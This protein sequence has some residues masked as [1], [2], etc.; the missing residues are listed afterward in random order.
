M[1]KVL[2]LFALSALFFSTSRAADEEAPALAR[3]PIPADFKL[4]IQLYGAGQSPL[5]G[6]ELVIRK[7]VAYEFVNDEPE[8]ITIIE[9]DRARLFLLD[10]KRKIQTELSARELD[11]A[12]ARIHQ[13]ITAS[14]EAQEK[15]GGKAN[16]IAASMNRNLC[17]PRLSITRDPAAHRLRLTN[18]SIEIDALGVPE[19]DQARVMSIVNSLAAFAKLA[20]LREPEN[21]SPFAYL[22]TLAALGPGE[23][24]RPTEIIL[25]FRLAGPPR[26][27]RWEF[28]LVP[29][30]TDREREAISRIDHFRSTTQFVRF[31]RYDA[32]DKR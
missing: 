21:V 3:S 30:L 25:L 4:M 6:A 27:V 7:G 32:D 10:L 26:K 16:R 11:N 2:R 24:L 9:P 28:K 5:S 12:L 15:A 18:P 8:E 29:T 31:D 14:I 22:E 20:A 13:R 19:P 1:I 17:E 23:H